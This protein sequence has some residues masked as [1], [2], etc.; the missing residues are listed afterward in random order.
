M[1]D[2]IEH[3]LRGRLGHLRALDEEIGNLLAALEW[4]LV[5]EQPDP[6]LVLAD[7]LL[8]AFNVT[9]GVDGSY[10][11][12]AGTDTLG[13]DGGNPA[14]RVIVAANLTH[15][16]WDAGR[17]EEGQAIRRSMLAEARALDDPGI[18][19]FGLYEASRSV[20]N[21]DRGFQL[22]TEAHEIARRV[23]IPGL[24]GRS[25]TIPIS[26]L[27][28]RGDWAGTEELG[29]EILGDPDAG[30]DRDRN[31][32]LGAGTSGVAHRTLRSRS[33][34]PRGI[35]RVRELTELFNS[36]RIRAQDATFWA[37]LDLAQGRDTGAVDRIVPILTEARH[38]NL[39]LAINVSGWVPGAWALAHNN[40]DAALTEFL[41]WRTRGRLVSGH[42]PRRLPAAR[43][44][45]R[46]TSRECPRR[47]RSCTRARE[48]VRPGRGRRQAHPARWDPDV[49]RG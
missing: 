47:A 27:G 38:R 1:H 26:Q 24:A 2:P 31:C 8:A 21:T 13:L 16:A 6:A 41:A 29:T 17:F 48:L 35:F 11:F 36:A 22:A 46:G 15:T 4:A 28:W 44:P 45:R 30:A 40:V 9:G 34:L 42:L 37:L 33:R 5:S 14:L 3:A 39:G 25:L 20:M 7:A 23:G 12:S 10:A 19:A 18:L 49:R 32:P 43:V